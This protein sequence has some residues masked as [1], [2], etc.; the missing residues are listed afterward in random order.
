MRS[1]INP[2]RVTYREICKDVRMFFGN[3]VH[4]KRELTLNG[5]PPLPVKESMRSRAEGD[6]ADAAIGLIT[7]AGQKDTFTSLD[8]CGG[9]KH[10]MRQVI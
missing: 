3:M 1:L 9:V 10:A 4:P 6:V 8:M 2:P 7:H 5:L